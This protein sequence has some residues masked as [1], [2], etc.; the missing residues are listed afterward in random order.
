MHDKPPEPEVRKPANLHEVGKDLDHEK[1]KEEFE[2]FPDHH[3]NRQRGTLVGDNR[4]ETRDKTRE[5]HVRANDFRL[6]SKRKHD[7][8][9]FETDPF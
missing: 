9:R 6:R 4:V 3:K 2:L 7:V 5:Q 8:E 1:L